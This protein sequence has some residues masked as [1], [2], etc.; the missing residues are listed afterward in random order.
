MADSGIL[1]KDANDFR[2]P[3]RRPWLF[4]LIILL[5]AG[6]FAGLKCRGRARG[7][8]SEPATASAAAADTS[9]PQQ[10]PARARTE[11]IAGGAARTSASGAATPA[12]PP[13]PPEVDRKLAQ[14][15]SHLDADQLVEARTVY[16]ALLAQPEAAAV[17]P[18]VEERL[19]EVNLQLV[20]T[21]RAMP[22]KE[23]YAIRSG[24]SLKVLAR[25]YGI[26]QELIQRS[27]NVG[28]PNHIQVGDRLRL[29]NK[30]AFELVIRKQAND[31]LLTLGGGFFKRYRVG[32]G[33]Y[34]RTPVGSF[35]ISGKV[36]NPPWWRPDG[37]EIPF[38]DPENVLGTRWMALEA[39]GTTL[40]AKGYGIHGSWDESGIGRQSSAG[41]IR[42]R[43]AEVEELYLLVP[44]GTPVRIEE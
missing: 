41:C 31:L 35:R 42:M 19:A 38:G 27:N 21:P 8:A 16:L 30:P 26:T 18:L 12:L 1:L 44:E 11:P 34:G 15:R 2:G 17:R 33:Q 3:S 23:E 14:A 20:L 36:E 7:R 9:L 39:T 40:P 5:G 29:L 28:D 22:E 37:R 4:L 25:R 43:N 13:A 6:V 24:D 32:T 10:P